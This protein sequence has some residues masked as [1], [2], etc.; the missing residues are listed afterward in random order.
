MKW[1][2]TMM[3]TLV[4]FALVACGDSGSD[5]AHSG[6]CEAMAAQEIA[7]GALGVA[8]RETFL[9]EC[10]T[11]MASEAEPFGN[12]SETCMSLYTAILT[13]S[14]ENSDCSGDDVDENNPCFAEH[15]AFAL[16]CGR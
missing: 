10:D 9:G 2:M 16:E 11:M 13:C 7:C 12:M 5:S 6:M 8:D 15:E 3:A 14:T 4:V 1:M